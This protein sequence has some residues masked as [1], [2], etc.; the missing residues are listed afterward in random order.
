[1]FFHIILLK[2]TYSSE[3]PLSVLKGHQDRVCRVAFHPSG[4]YIAS[5]SF[6]TTWRLWDVNTAKEL[7]LQE[8][9]SKEV[10]SVEFQNDGSLVAS[11]WVFFL[12]LCR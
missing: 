7:L 1:M 12:P 4:D 2:S 6:D 9:H 5:A 8:G 3:T 10:Y 11:G